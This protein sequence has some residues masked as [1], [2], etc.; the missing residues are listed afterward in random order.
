MPTSG[1][2]RLLNDVVPG[3]PRASCS[4]FPENTLTAPNGKSRLTQTV[5][6]PGFPGRK[7]AETGGFSDPGSENGKTGSTVGMFFSF[8]WERREVKRGGFLDGKRGF[9]TVLAEIL[10]V[11]FGA[12]IRSSEDRILTCSGTP[13]WPGPARSA[14]FYPLDW[15]KPARKL[16]ESGQ[17]VACFEPFPR[18]LTR[19]TCFS[20][21]SCQLFAIQAAPL[22]GS[23]W[24]VM[25]L[26]RHL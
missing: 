11:L 13:F 18:L 10:S 7:T 16:P 14:L 26:F 23:G 17:K 25:M 5:V 6:F 3:S 21:L 15:P 2:T 9:L 12:G 8:S 20:T 1:T 4:W 19:K 24:K 22:I